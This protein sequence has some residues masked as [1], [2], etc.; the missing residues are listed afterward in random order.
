MNHSAIRALLAC[1]L[2][3]STPVSGEDAPAKPD[4]AKEADKQIARLDSTDF[5][6]RESALKKL[7]ELDPAALPYLKSLVDSKRS[8]S[9]EVRG[10]LT[11]VVNALEAKR[12]SGETVKGTTV[13]L[14]LSKAGPKEIL[15]ELAK[16][17][18]AEP[19]PDFETRL[20]AEP[21]ADFNFTGS[22][23]EAI[24][25]LLRL[26]PPKDNGKWTREN[27]A[28]SRAL[29]RWT[30][31]D[32][33]GC[34]LPHAIA[35]V[36]RI[37]VGHVALERNAKGQALTLTLVPLVE[38]RY[39]VDKLKVQVDTFTLSA[40]KALKPQWVFQP[41]PNNANAVANQINIP[42]LVRAGAD[43][44]LSPL[45]FS[46]QA[47][48]FFAAPAADLL[49]TDRLM[50]L[51][52]SVAMTIRETDEVE[53]TLREVASPINLPGGY[54]FS[55]HSTREG[56]EVQLSGGGNFNELGHHLRDRVLF[57]DANGTALDAQFVSTSLQG[58][59]QGF[60]LVVK[61]KVTGNPVKVRVSIP[62]KPLDVNVPFKIKD[63]A[64]P[65]AGDK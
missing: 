44:L 26:Y 43:G 11:M 13:S 57:L 16:Q 56:I 50:S 58:G 42:F 4:L 9:E 18:H 30:A 21:A 12:A 62:G 19:L 51:E 63:V 8:L 31:E 20:P 6:E 45:L 54:T 39:E 34:A 33:D 14:R 65:V 41:K 17:V 38:P 53:K 55:A 23:W 2:L 10:R 32:Y 48:C 64:L 52:G 37:R 7:Q 59:V 40:G 60:T 3:G 46:P 24:D 1:F 25:Q 36:C 22:Y 49:A 28:E 29:N 5:D 27:L 35:E 47:E 15:Q 61:S